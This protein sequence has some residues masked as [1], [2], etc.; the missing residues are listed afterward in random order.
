M[1]FL[2][3]SVSHATKSRALFTATETRVPD[4]VWDTA[5]DLIGPQ[6]SAKCM[7]NLALPEARIRTDPELVTALADL[8]LLAD[9][10]SVV[11]RSWPQQKRDIH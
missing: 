3:T 5:L 1:T 11:R 4:W 7:P 6:M 10:D 8:Y 9:R 2:A